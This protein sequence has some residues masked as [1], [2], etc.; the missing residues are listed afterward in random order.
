LAIIDRIQ[1]SWYRST[2][3]TP[4]TNGKY[5]YTVSQVVMVEITDQD[6]ATG[7]GWVSGN[8]TVYQ[9]VLEWA[10]QI[11]GMETDTIER[12]YDRLYQPKLIG[13]KGL[14]TRAVSALDIALWDHL[15]QRT[16][17]SVHRL[18][19]G[20]RDSIPVYIAG[21]YYQDGKGVSQLADE[22]LGY[23]ASGAKAVKMKIGAL[24][25][26]QDLLRVQA[27]RDA[28][29]DEVD[30]LVDANGAYRT[31]MARQMA[32]R[33][34]DLRVFWF[35]EPLSAE[36]LAGYRLLRQDGAVTIAHGENEYTRYGFRDLIAGQTVDV[37]NADAQVLGGISEWR[38]VA[39]FANAYEI[40]IAPHGNQEIHIH[41]VTAVPGGLILEYYNENVV[42][43][44]QEMLVERLPLNPD[45]TVSVPHAPGLG[46]HLDQ[47]V[48][49]RYLVASE[50]I[51]PSQA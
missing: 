43:L 30:I 13:R 6:G 23:V 47:S 40:P 31:D 1:V 5:T 4:I 50:S 10:P 20:Y 44:M 16:G 18:L 22:M 32:R 33:L 38:K 21:G 19:G 17:L 12:I 3:P 9:A 41:L 27:V 29:G 14:S 2:F 24:P 28:V 35:E 11:M 49:A 42:G 26:S 46:V 39:S 36:N 7:I 45:G 15:G 51:S 48:L 25:L 8:A 34:A 37:I